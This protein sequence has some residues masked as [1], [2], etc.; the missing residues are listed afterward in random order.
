MEKEKK[1]RRHKSP[2]LGIKRGPHNRFT[3]IRKKICA[4]KEFRM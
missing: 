4:T 1:K 3:H 2:T